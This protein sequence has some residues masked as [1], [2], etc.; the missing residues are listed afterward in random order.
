MATSETE[1]R[2]IDELLPWYM[3]GTLDEAEAERV[4]RFLSEKP[5]A[6]AEAEVTDSLLKAV[7][8]DVPVPMLTHDRIERVMTRLDDEPQEVRAGISGRIRRWWSG[9]S[10]DQDLR[11]PAAVTMAIALVTVLLVMQPQ[12][13]KDVFRTLSSDRPTVAMQIEVADGINT[14]SATA[15]FEEYSLIAEQQP[16]GGYLITL[17]GDTSVAELFQMLEALRS[18]ER[19]ADARVLTDE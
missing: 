3:N 1:H 8:D 6:H 9:L 19:V 16:D 13:E 12:T 4:R 2:E 7:A 10:F 17:P 11:I 14:A 18:D 15:L 5:D